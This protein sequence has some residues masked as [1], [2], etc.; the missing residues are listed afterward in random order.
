MKSSWKNPKER[1]LYRQIS[2]RL[3]AVVAAMKP[4]ERVASEPE[5]SREFGVSRFTIARAMQEL[6][7]DG[8]VHR[9]QGAGSFAASPSLRRSPG[10]LLSFSEAVKASGHVVSNKLLEFG[11]TKWRNGVPFSRATPL[12][13]LSRLRLVDGRPVAKH[14]S[15]LSAAT[16]NAIGLTE[17]LATDPYL[18]LY[19]LFE[20]AG[21]QIDS[22]VERLRARRPSAIECTQLMLEDA[23]VVAV[24]RC[25]YGPDG[26]IVDF[27]EAVY[28]A[29]RYG[30]ESRIVRPR[31]SLGDGGLKGM[32]D[33]SVSNG[34][35]GLVHTLGGPRLG[36]W[37]R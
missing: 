35:Q 32:K 6:V 7:E 3:R 37:P 21:V 25:S 14:S 8:L 22:A 36:P 20:Q 17:Q 4:G 5:L 27:A 31:S 26:Q 19:S 12:Y 29:R 23:V 18:S 15:I 16:V 30:Y 11:P 34:I 33:G 9:R 24:E 13:V 2:D 10:E 28:D 1:P